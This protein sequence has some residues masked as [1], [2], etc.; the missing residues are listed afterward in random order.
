MPEF[1]AGVGFG[2]L[3]DYDVDTCTRTMRQNHGVDNHTSTIQLPCSL[4]SIPHT[5]DKL[6]ADEE[7]VSVVQDHEDVPLNIVAEG[8]DCEVGERTGNEVKFRFATEK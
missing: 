2:E 4:R 6:C 8:V 7:D 5:Q 1:E 3:V